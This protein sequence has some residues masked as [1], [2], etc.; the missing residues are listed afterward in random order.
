MNSKTFRMPARR[1]AATTAASL[2]ATGPVALAAAVPAH[3][4]GDE[5]KASAAVLRTRL[6]VGLLDKTV[7]VPLEASL[8]AVQAP[9]TAEKTALTVRLD[10]VEQGGPVHL[11]R[12]DVAT[13]KATADRDRAEASSNLAQ[14]RVHVPGLPLLSLIKVEK[15]SSKAVCEAGSRPVAEANVLGAVTVLGKK[16]TLS[17]GGVTEVDVPKIGKVTLTLSKTHTTSTT[18]AAAALELEVSVDPLDLNVAEVEGA[19]TL[20]EASCESP[21]GAPPGTEQPTGETEDSSSTAQDGTSDD[22]GRTSGVTAQ[23]AAEPQQQ[24]LAATGGSTA[25]P[26]IAGGAVLLLGLGGGAIVLSRARGR[27]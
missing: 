14:A 18:A 15:V 12:A 8:N 25:T 13:A 6:D 22:E 2:L 23:S 1:L 16:V 5:G 10:G 20:A 27:G 19:I 26:L 4:T 9:A 7:H 24:D 21:K 17:S 3:A 11:L